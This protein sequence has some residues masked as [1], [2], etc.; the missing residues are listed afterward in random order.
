M[1]GRW[2][3]Y[4]R[5]EL[6]WIEA[7]CV[8]PRKARYA[9]FCAL[10]G[11]TD[12]SEAN[13]NALCKRNRWLTGRTGR[14]EAGNASWN[15]GKKM[16]F[17]SNSAATQFKK[18]QLPH[19]YRGAG[20]EMVDPK[21]GYVWLIVDARNPHTGAATNRVMKHRWLWEQVNGP[22]PEGMRLKSLDGD[23]ANT[24]PSN[25]VA[26]PDALGP[27]LNG[28]F[29]R[30]YDTAPAELKP[31]IMAVAKLEHKARQLKRGGTRP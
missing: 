16:P 22:V 30:G 1:K 15:K 26:I 21:D 6:A 2:V 3:N 7:N 25:W 8:L 28:R 17:S 11:R 29:G 4:F 20:H 14:I 10:F 9:E 12:V 24:D 31:T 18:G 19:T 23:R 5:E 27:R 13:L